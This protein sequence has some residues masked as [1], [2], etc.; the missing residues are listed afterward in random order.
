MAAQLREVRRQKRAVSAG[1]A[2][3]VHDMRVAA[4]RLQADL[5]LFAGCYKRRD[6][7]R[8][9]SG[10]RRLGRSL[11]A[12]RD[13]E[14][15]LEELRSGARAAGLE[16]SGVLVWL[17]KRHARQRAAL[18]VY[19]DGR[20]YR[21]WRKRFARLLK[22]STAGRGLTRQARVRDLL[23]GEI[24]RRYGEVRAF[25][26]GIAG[27]TATQLHALRSAGKRFRYT[28]EAFREQ[29]GDD[30]GRLLRDLREMQDALGTMH[31]A[32]LLVALLTE[33]S[34][35]AGPKDPLQPYLNEERGRALEARA[36]FERIWPSITGKTFRL[37]LASAVATL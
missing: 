12:V 11:G 10:L 30:A 21:R 36:Q 9:A 14:V 17:E 1:T 19:L 16:T 18:L 37:E 34:E 27:A 4:R 15:M 13:T 5:S 6:R 29:L 35:D 33:F 3:A 32:Q 28:L 24:W 20:K 22:R 23:P 31:D 7:K 26:G 2:G 25:E 8:L